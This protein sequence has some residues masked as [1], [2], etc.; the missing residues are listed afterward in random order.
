MVT[1]LL[2]DI[3]AKKRDVLIEVLAQDPRPSYQNA[4]ERMYFM[5]F[6]EFEVGFTVEDAVLT[7]HKVQK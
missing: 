5:P 1:A 2:A 4:P 3:P 7:V 6:G